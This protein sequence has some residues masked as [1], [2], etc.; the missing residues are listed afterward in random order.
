L[1]RAD[2]T[3]CTSNERPDILADHFEHK[4]W[5]ID[6]NR[7]RETPDANIPRCTSASGRTFLDYAAAVETGYIT[8]EE[9]RMSIRKVKNNMSPEPDGIPVEFLK[10]L[11]DDGLELIRNILNNCWENEIMPD[12][13]ELAE[14]VTL[15]KKGNVEDPANYRPIALLNTIYK[16][17]AAILQKRLAA[18]LDEK[19]WETQYGFRKKRSTAQPLF[20]TR[21]LQDLAES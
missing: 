14:L 4:Q 1:I 18:G 11:D 10:L 20:I 19:L 12:E 7:E 6:E 15:Y 16:L 13:M 17:Y 21:R 3:V 8:I 5:G 9:I 2:G